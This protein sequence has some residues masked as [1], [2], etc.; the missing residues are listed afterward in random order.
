MK[1]QSSS[2]IDVN[3]VRKKRIRGRPVSSRPEVQQEENKRAALRFKNVPI[4]V[5]ILLCE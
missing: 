4:P 1:G 5:Q 3:N 2:Y